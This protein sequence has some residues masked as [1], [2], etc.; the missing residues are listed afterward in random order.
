MGDSQKHSGRSQIQKSTYTVSISLE[1]EN[2]FLKKIY[3]GRI[4]KWLLEEGR[5][6]LTGKGHKRTF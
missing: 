6:K 2:R 3:D 5:E 1:S 4:R